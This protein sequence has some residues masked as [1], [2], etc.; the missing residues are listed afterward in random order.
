M[1]AE[2]L[3][4]LGVGDALEAMAAGRTSSVELT[5]ALLARMDAL[6]PSLNALTWYDAEDALS[7]A[8]AADA[9]R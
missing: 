9:A 5:Q 7:Q 3:I 6:Q 1:R 2:E 4:E 8:R